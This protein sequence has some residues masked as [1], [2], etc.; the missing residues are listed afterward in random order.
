MGASRPTLAIN[1]QS[2]SE[3]FATREPELWDRH[4]YKVP[5]TKINGTL[6]RK[7]FGVLD[8]KTLIS[9]FSEFIRRNNVTHFFT[10]TYH[11]RSSWQARYKAFSE[12]I[13]AIEWL[14]GRPVG[15]LRGDE[16]LRFSGCGFPEIPEHHHGVLIDADNISCRTAE[17]L[18]REF[19]DALIEKYEPHRNA[20]RYC[21]KHAFHG[22]GDWDLGGKALRK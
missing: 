7:E 22:C 21:L 19:G 14:Q 12:W 20:V 6:G 17:D 8:S 13:D 16:M 9:S 18:W 11:R 4:I 3:K 15:W 5:Q 1:K 10:L 2:Q